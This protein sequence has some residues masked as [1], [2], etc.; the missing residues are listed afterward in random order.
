MADAP[1]QSAMVLAAGLGT[2]L[3]PLTDTCPKP[4][5]EVGGQTM[6]A[7][8]LDLLA[9]SGVKRAV[10]NAHYLAAQI[11]AAVA[12]M[13]PHYAMELI[14]SDE[15][16]R[17]LD[18]AGGIIN[19]LPLLGRAPFFVLNADSFWRD[20]AGINNLARL[21]AA[22]APQNM[23][24]L[25]LTVAQGQS[26][27]GQKGDFIMAENGQLTRAD[28]AAN[29]PQAVIYAGAMALN[30]SIFAHAGADFAGAKPEPQ[31]LNLYFDRAIA[32]GRLYGLPLAGDW[33]SVGS[34]A[35]LQAAEARLKTR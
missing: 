17:L 19:A 29:P 23:D 12:A 26:L 28:K 10:I 21:K 14:V 33:F 4:L 7:R 6:L 34:A 9:A 31:S 30:P 1:F 24:M 16:S 22:F 11:Q 27:V 18:S 15:S 32:A 35:E 5:I 2:R 8:G 25:L 13:Q 3:R 20:S